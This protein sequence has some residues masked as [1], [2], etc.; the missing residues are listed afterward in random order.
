MRLITDANHKMKV[1]LWQGG[2]KRYIYARMDGE[3]TDLAKVPLISRQYKISVG[4]T[5]YAAPV[6]GFLETARIINIPIGKSA[7]IIG[8]SPS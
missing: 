5:V 7:T 8:R 1:A 6:P 4:D 3:G 2:K